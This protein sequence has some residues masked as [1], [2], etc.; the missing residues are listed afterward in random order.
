MTKRKQQKSVKKTDI[1]HQS[2]KK[3]VWEL[4]SNSPLPYLIILLG[5]ALIYFQ[6]FS[7]ILGKLDEDLIILNNFSFINNI[8][9]LKDAVFR[10]AFMTTTGIP[11]YRPLQNA[12]YLFDAFISGGNHWSFF[13]TNI[14]IH[15]VTSSFVYYLLKSLLNDKKIS[16]ICSLFF[17][18]NPFFVHSVSWVPSRGDLLI[19]MFA[20]MSFV[21]L[22]KYFEEK[23]TYLF[24]LHIVSLALAV[25]SKE[26]AMFV[27][28]I[29]LLYIAFTEKGIKFSKTNILLLVSYFVVGTGYL[30]LRSTV[31]KISNSSDVFGITP[32][33]ANLP[34]L[35]EIICKFFIPV[36]LSPTPAFHVVNILIGLAVFSGLIF[37][38]VKFS[39]ENG[40]A[41]YSLLIFG[42][43]WFVLLNIPAMLFTHNISDTSYQYQES[44]GYLPSIGL[45]VLLCL[46]LSLFIKKFTKQVIFI[47]IPVILFFIGYT[48]LYNMNYKT[49]LSFYD[50]AVRTNPKSSIS[51]NNRGIIK[52]NLGDKAGALRDYD[53]TIALNSRV[54]IA[55]YNRG[56]VRSEL[57]MSKGAIED[58]TEFLRT[59][60]DYP[61]AYNA[62]AMEYKKIGKLNEAIA[63]FKEVQRLIPGNPDV[64]NSIGIC[65]AIK[66]DLKSAL[67]YFNDVI[68]IKS[69]NFEAYAN[70]GNVRHALGAVSGAIEDWKVAAMHG[71]QSAKQSL[72]HF[73]KK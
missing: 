56:A 16:L 4:I 28:F 32:F 2:P 54:L 26:T 63:D 31:V 36:N 42:I 45:I 66:G 48:Y 5:I 14:L 29:F 17:A 24:I 59:K 33:I 71:N 19:T 58:F 35:P 51:Y 7:F 57:G 50:L 43:L 67:N 46:I 9:N 6:N 49:P 60:K 11:F 22:I 1:S 30:L 70:R 38:I 55:Y 23:K 44:R 25:L 37:L 21:F 73:I 61:E 15:F 3:D 13:L 18:L 69:D 65:E 34:V 12:S 68:K 27:P 72:Q 39:N 47:F 64:L 62:R 40:F 10:D 41:K 8:G 52:K 20:A 53:S